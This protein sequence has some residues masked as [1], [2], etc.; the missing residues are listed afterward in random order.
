MRTSGEMSDNLKPITMLFGR[1]IAFADDVP[2]LGSLGEITLVNPFAGIQ[3]SW[4][5][6][7]VMRAK[8]WQRW[9]D[10]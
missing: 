1:P 6:R 7:L 4:W 10:Q 5:D 3:L 2:T 9:R 8:N